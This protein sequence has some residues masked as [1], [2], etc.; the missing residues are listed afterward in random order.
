MMNDGEPDSGCTRRRYLGLIGAASTAAAVG[1]SQVGSAAE[2]GQ[3]SAGYGSAGYG[4]QS[5]GGGNGTVTEPILEVATVGTDAVDSASATLVGELTGLKN[6]D[7]VSV[8]FEWGPSN[9]GLS[10]TTPEQ[11]LSSTGQF[12][13]TLSGL[14]A[15]TEYDFRAVATSGDTTVTGG[16]DTFSTDAADTSEPVEGTPQI[17][18]L[19]GADVSNPNNPH[20]TAELE[21]AASIDASELY[22]ATLT[23]SGSDGEIETWHYGLGG[24]TASATE[25]RRIPYHERPEGAEYTVDL[26]V[27]SY[28]GNIDQRTTTFKAQ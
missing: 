6:A 18:S 24:E 3:G 26:V 13:A 2:P 20:V 22:A 7:S 21:W 4:S 8:R 9:E 5:Y 25:T 11:T 1:A 23:V 16:T 17:E 10:E 28:Y 14:A 19:T 12:E 15:D 27:Y